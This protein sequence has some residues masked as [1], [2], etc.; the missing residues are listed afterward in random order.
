MLLI[1]PF[2]KDQNISDSCVKP[3]KHNTTDEQN[4]SNFTKP[5]REN[6]SN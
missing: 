6:Y 3:I 1:P 2:S 5:N 4:E